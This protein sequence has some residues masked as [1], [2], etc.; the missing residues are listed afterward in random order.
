MMVQNEGKR[1]K[2][3]DIY[4]FKEKKNVLM[5][6]LKMNSR[7]LAKTAFKFSI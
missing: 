2:K 6:I 4:F 3:K 7:R 5:I 1:K